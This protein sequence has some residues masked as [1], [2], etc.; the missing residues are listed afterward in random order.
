LASISASGQCRAASPFSRGS[1]GAFF[2][3]S[4]FTDIRAD[5]CMPAA[6]RMRR[7]RRDLSGKPRFSTDEPAL[8]RV[9][10]NVYLK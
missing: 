6:G 9:F 10:F 8:K 5:I 4:D 2:L 3:L 1:S 7:S